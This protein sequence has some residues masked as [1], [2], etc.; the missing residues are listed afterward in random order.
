MLIGNGNVF[1]INGVIISHI[2]FIYQVL[3]TFLE[4]KHLILTEPAHYGGVLHL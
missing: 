2:D 1:D 4:K 3:D